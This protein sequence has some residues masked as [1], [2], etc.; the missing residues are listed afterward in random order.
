[1]RVRPAV[2]FVA[3]ALILAACSDE[4]GP[5]GSQ[6]T[7]TT[8]VAAISTPQPTS[9][10]TPLPRPT[11]TPTPV[12]IIPA[13]SVSDQGIEEDGR[14]IV[15]EVVA[16]EPGWLV[17]QTEAG[18]E[19]GTVLGYAAVDEG[20]SE[21]VQV[22]IE[23]AGAD[24]LLRAVLHVDSGTEG[25]FEYPGPDQPVRID[26]E[27]VANVFEVNFSAFEP[28]VDVSDQDVAED[29]LVTFENVVSNGPGWLVL[30]LD[31]A[32]EPGRILEY[33]PVRPGINEGLS[34]TVNWR[35]ATPTVH[36]ILYE[37]GGEAG[38][39]EVPDTDTAVEVD[40]APVASTFQLRMP[41]DIFALDQPVVN[42]EVIVERVIS[43][44][45]GWLVVFF[46]E[47]GELGLIIGEA[48]LEDGVNEMVAVPVIETAVTPLLHLM[49]HQDHE[50]LGEFQF[51][52]S[53]PPV[54]YEERLPAPVTIQTDEGN[55]LISRDQALSEDNTLIVPLVVVDV[56]AWVVLYADASGEPVEIIG[57]TWA[58][59]GINRDVAVEVDPEL[60]TNVMHV[61][62]HLDAASTQEFDYPDGFD[63]PLQRSRSIIS[64]P[65][66]LRTDADGE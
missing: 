33:T 61:I 31:D 34:M 22:T 39:F 28:A 23:A 17:I 59:A 40:D 9:T 7:G 6:A 53:D 14:L 36:A 55:Y 44:G 13:V 29:G 26:S 49:V 62:L 18:G 57:M 25:T 42:G 38:V 50:P 64:S 24:P 2:L 58:P 21:Q 12:P 1:M 32:G 63:V 3:M 54:L 19:A 52:A 8:T 60:V 4:A 56:D 37:D 48:V 15:D 51:P 66:T 41:P 16:V 35:M 65:F 20:E 10:A 45:P 47:E 27:T 30:Y 46:D 43:Y 5:D 11:A